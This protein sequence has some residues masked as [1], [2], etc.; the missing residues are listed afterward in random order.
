MPAPY[1]DLVSPGAAELGELAARARGHRDDVHAAICDVIEP[2]THGTVVRATRQPSY[3]DFNVVRVEGDP[4]MDADAL[5]AFADEAQAG[6][7]H[8]KLDFD[9]V[10][11]AEP[12]R[13]AFEERG[14]M[15]TRIVSMRHE[16]PLPPGSGIAVEEVPYEAAGELRT[17]WHQED[18]PGVE[19]GSYQAEAR[20]VAMTFGAR[21]LAVIEDGAPVGFAQ[22]ERIYGSG[23][24][25]S[26]YVHPEFR[27]AG[28]GT[29]LTRAAIEAVGDCEDIW[30]VAD[31]EG[32]AKDVYGRLGFRP[33]WVTM[34][35]LLP[36][37]TDDE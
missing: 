13:A 23:E 18:F 1:A 22:V 34:E 27:G 29:A 31:D 10:E 32:A 25:T 2:W 37:R 24:V 33:A 21:V 30:I 14:W 17:A 11:V 6:M 12:L 28:R 26:V 9:L 5:G 19:Q 35:F 3:W 15:V 16:D 20:E 7:E 36:P 4:G 8:R